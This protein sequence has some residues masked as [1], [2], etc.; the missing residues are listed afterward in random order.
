MGIFSTKSALSFCLMAYFKVFFQ[1][2]EVRRMFVQLFHAVP[3]GKEKKMCLLPPSQIREAAHLG[4]LSHFT[5]FSFL[6]TMTILSF[7]ESLLLAGALAKDKERMEKYRDAGTRAAFLKGET[8]EWG[9]P[10]M[11]VALELAEAREKSEGGGRQKE[12]GK[13]HLFPSD[14]TS[15]F[16]QR[17]NI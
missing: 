16:C 17:G 4:S 7:P 9:L 12:E 8:Y 2:W 14:G 10:L 3:R 6:E 11:G 15:L 5:F 1:E 13:P